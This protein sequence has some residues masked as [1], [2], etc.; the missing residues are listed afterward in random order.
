VVNQ[1]LNLFMDL[2]GDGT[3]GSSCSILGDLGMNLLYLN[4]EQ[5]T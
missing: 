3:T 1:N 5:V 2:N 4:H